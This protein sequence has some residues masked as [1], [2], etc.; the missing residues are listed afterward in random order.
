VATA[1]SQE[2]IDSAHRPAFLFVEGRQKMAE[3]PKRG[4]LCLQPAN[5]MACGLSAQLPH[6]VLAV[7]CVYKTKKAA[8][9]I[10][11]KDAEL[12]EVFVASKEA[13]NG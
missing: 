10:H 3:K 4:W 13:E 9:A 2:P 7:L 11:G 5:F 12:M 6:D 8:R 1:S